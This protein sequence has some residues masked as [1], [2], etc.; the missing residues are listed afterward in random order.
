MSGLIKQHR[1]RSFSQT[2]FAKRLGVARSTV[3]DLE[4]AK[5]TIK[6]ETYFEA[7]VILELDALIAQP[8]S[9]EL[10]RVTLDGTKHRNRSS[11]IEI[12][13]DF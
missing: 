2:E 3:H 11:S 1:V 4:S 6:I 5:S 9:T 12:E 10:D 13:D 8:M 7:L